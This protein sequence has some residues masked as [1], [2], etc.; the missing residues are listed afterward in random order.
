MKILPAGAELFHADGQTD[1]T[2]V[3]A[4]FRNFSNPP[5]EVGTGRWFC[6]S[7]RPVLTLNL[8][9]TTIVA[10]PSNASKWQ[11]EFNSAFKGL[12]SPYGTTPNQSCHHGS[13]FTLLLT[14]DAE[15]FRASA[16]GL[17]GSMGKVLSYGNSYHVVSRVVSSVSADCVTM[18]VWAKM[19]TA[20]TT[21]A[22]GY[23][24]TI[25]TASHFGAH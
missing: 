25:Y 21:E 24:E 18:N 6:V 5:D 22:A 17:S 7:V 9:R 19:S 2:K 14:A 20:K 1:M 8:L 13:R 4:A 12:K 23:T 11:M 3:V 10:P 15:P 16:C